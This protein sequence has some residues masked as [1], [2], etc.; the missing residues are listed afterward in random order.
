MQIR[1]KENWNG[2]LPPHNLRKGSLKMLLNISLLS[3]DDI[4]FLNAIEGIYYL[5]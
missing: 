3:E 1:P 2:V 4:M 5:L